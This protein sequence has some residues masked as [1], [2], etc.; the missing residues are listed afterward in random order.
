MVGSPVIY[1][2]LRKKQERKIAHR[3]IVTTRDIRKG[4]KIIHEMIAY[5]R[6]GTGLLPKFTDFVIGRKA[7]RII[8][9]GELITLEKLE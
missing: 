6:P 1:P 3:S 9:T 4:E 7:N 8:K 2:T 5:K